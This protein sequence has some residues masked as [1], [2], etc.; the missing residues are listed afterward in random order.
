ML[1]SLIFL[2][3]AIFKFGQVGAVWP[4]SRFLARAM[5]PAPR[6]RGPGSVIVEIGAGTGSLTAEIAKVLDP[7]AKLILIEMEPDFTPILRKRFPQALTIEGDAQELA[8]H[9][10]AQGIQHVDCVI[11][12][13][14]FTN[15]PVQLC[16]NIL[17]EVRSVLGPGGEMVA[18][19]YIHSRLLPGGKRFF[20]MLVETFPRV[21]TRRVFFNIPSA[22]VYRLSAA[23][24]KM[25]STSPSAH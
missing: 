18:F 12:G 9:L 19:Q 23:A 14:P 11:S 1:R 20:R 4:S 6:H 16:R 10:E 5:V 15:F 2:K 3:K 17:Q 8:S 22:N 13:L 21:H 7:D 24:A 25:L